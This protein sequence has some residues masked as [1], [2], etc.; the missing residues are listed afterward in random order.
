MAPEPGEALFLYLTTSV[1][2]VSMVLV[3][4]RMEQACQGDTG[5]PPVEDDGPTIMEIADDPEA[6]GL[7]PP[8][9]SPVKS[10]KHRGP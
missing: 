1:E 7:E 8:D 5:V 3:A 6:R 9:P 10:Q 2:A 4:E